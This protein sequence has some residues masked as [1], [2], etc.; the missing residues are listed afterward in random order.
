MKGVAYGF[1]LAVAIGFLLRWVRVACEPKLRKAY[2]DF[3][4]D[5]SRSAAHQAVELMERKLAEQD[6]PD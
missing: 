5:V 3:K 4:Y 2:L 6:L 1:L